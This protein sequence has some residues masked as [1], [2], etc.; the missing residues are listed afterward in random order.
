MWNGIDECLQKK[1]GYNFLKNYTIRTYEQCV[2]NKDC[3]K[4][5]YYFFIYIFRNIKKQIILDY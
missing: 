3:K 5:H 4:M 2:C 1:S